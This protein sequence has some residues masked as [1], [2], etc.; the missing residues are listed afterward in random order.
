MNQGTIYKSPTWVIPPEERRTA[1]ALFNCALYQ[2]KIDIVPKLQKTFN[3]E[4]LQFHYFS[5]TD[6]LVRLCKR[7]PLDLIVIAVDGDFSDAHMMIMEAKEQMFLS[8]VPLVVYYP[9]DDENI[10]RRA[11]DCEADELFV[12]AWDQRGFEV[13]LKMLLKRS[14]RDLGVN[15]SSRLPGPSMIDKRV[16]KLIDSKKDFAVCYLDIDNFKA[17]NDYYGYFYGDKVIRLTAQIVRD[18]VFDLVPDGFIGHI[19]GD[20]FIFIIPYDKIDLIC[21]NIIKTFDR[22]IPYRYKEE[23][24]VRGRI[25]TRN[26]FEQDEVYPM[27]TISIAV[28]VCQNGAFSHSGEMSHMLADLKKYT[29]KLAGSNYMI[30][31]RKKY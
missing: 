3:G 20:D 8:I 22:L 6:E 9:G 11:L 21:S 30:E 19:G 12:G 26:R 23:D 25:I 31:R 10:Y 16:N 15:P 27:L 17:Y 5:N 7:Y 24:R 1:S 2:Q 29:K 28:L 13:R 14:R 4:K 18:I